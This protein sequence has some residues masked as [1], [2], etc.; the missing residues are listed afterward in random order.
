[1]RFILL[2]ASILCICVLTT[3]QIARLDP[4]F[5]EKHVSL[6]KGARLYGWCKAA[7]SVQASPESDNTLIF[8]VGAAGQ[9]AAWC[10]GY[11]SAIVDS[12]PLRKSYF[13]PDTKVRPTQYVG[14]VTLYLHDH[15]E[16]W[17]KPA[18]SLAHIAFRQ[19]FQ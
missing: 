11:V 10:Y 4:Y 13:A 2:L 9:N 6:I 16:L 3:A 12:M 19:K 18:A 14:V 1:M 15:P 17:D 8:P 5:A 7:E